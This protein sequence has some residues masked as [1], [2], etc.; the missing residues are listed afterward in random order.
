MLRQRIA[1]DC[2]SR[3]GW[4]LR[5][6]TISA[7]ASGY[8]GRPGP[9]RWFALDPSLVRVSFGPADF[10]TDLVLLGIVRLIL[11]TFSPPE[12]EL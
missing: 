11:A 4:H 6:R 10:F 12:E 9:A 5:V 2:S 3:V 1:V 7:A 8:G